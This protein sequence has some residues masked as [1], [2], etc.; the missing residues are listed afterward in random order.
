MLEL[1]EEVVPIS[2]ADWDM[3]TNHHVL[4]HPKKECTGD[5][6]KK[7][8]YKLANSVI[9]TGHPNFPESVHGAKQ[10]WRLIVEK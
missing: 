4:F 7:K 9:P 1:V 5:Q 2:G 8:F 3:V 10:I 6:L